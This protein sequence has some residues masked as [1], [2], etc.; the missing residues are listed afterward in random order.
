MQRLANA[1]V[2]FDEIYC[3]TKTAPMSKR[4][5]RLK[6]VQNGSNMEFAMMKA[7]VLVVLVALDQIARMVIL[8]FLS[9]P[10]QHD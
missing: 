4:Q 3:L 6:M 1:L 10:S 5:T 7:E 2:Y 9:S 8:S